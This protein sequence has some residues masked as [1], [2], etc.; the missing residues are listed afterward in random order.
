MQLQGLAQP[1]ELHNVQQ[2]SS[3]F[4]IAMNAK[5]FRVLSS[6]IYQDKIGSIVREL[7]ANAMDAHVM[8]GVDRPFRIHFPDQFEP[9]FEVQDYGTGIAPDKI[10]SVFTVYFN[11][12]KDQSNDVI[13]AFGLGS[14]TPF[15]YTDQFTV[16]N[17]YNGKQYIYSAF[18]AA[19]GQPS[20]VLLDE[21]DTIECNGL[22]ISM[23]VKA[24]D[25]RKFAEAA[26]VQLRFLENQPV[27][28]NAPYG[29]EVVN[30]FKDAEI[31]AQAQGFVLARNDQ[32][33]NFAYAVQGQI[34]YAIDT[35]K[36]DITHPS[37]KFLKHLLEFSSIRIDFN[38]G[39][40]GV[41]ASREAVEYTP[42]TVK[43]IRDKIAAIQSDLILSYQQ[44]I[45]QQATNWD[46]AV[47]A[48]S[49]DMFSIGA[50]FNAYFKPQFASPSS[51]HNEWRFALPTGVVA[52][53]KSYYGRRSEGNRYVTPT[54]T[55]KVYV[56]TAD[57][58]Y[59]QKRTTE[60]F[61][62]LSYNDIVV[63]IKFDKDQTNIEEIKKALG[64]CSDLKMLSD[65]PVVVEPRARAA[66]VKSTAWVIK[67]YDIRNVKKWER[68]TE[69]FE[70][71]F[72][73]DCIVFPVAAY[74]EVSGSV[75]TQLLTL[76]KYNTAMY[77]LS[78]NIY[79]VREKDYQQ[80][81]DLGAKPLGEYVANIT[82]EATQMAKAVKSAS[83]YKKMAANSDWIEH[84]NSV[85]G[86]DI[87]DYPQEVQKAQRVL[88]KLKTNWRT[89][90]KSRVRNDY[91]L[92]TYFGSENNQ[93]VC[94]PVV[95]GAVEKIKEY[96]NTTPIF[97]V[98][99]YQLRNIA[100]EQLRML[101]KVRTVTDQKGVNDGNEQW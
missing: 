72:D 21:S 1:V 54:K 77:N 92:Q 26:K 46:I 53:I 57:C 73:S 75:N 88:E 89:K 5:A 67:K 42:E 68:V 47:E 38:I 32:T 16:T 6:T 78:D 8:A 56:Q 7:S 83:N 2:S 86:L 64:G 69:D 62:S 81:I 63:L 66:G 101:M 60:I 100:T 39:E 9:H 44:R 80:A 59:K 84:N 43:V 97:K 30:P 35:D 94:H 27:Y 17:R 50:G 20:L 29:F 74:R 24:E 87:E 14:K 79:A 3:G 82:E 96:M 95:E 49:M 76:D 40:I 93:G 36:L 11:S 34:G 31:L 13:G 15:S 55:T 70:K 41:T 52:I 25:Y 71:L 45:Q 98:D 91:Y 22:C 12:T 90:L 65:V 48:N 4:Q 58:T 99:R 33:V 28:E 85:L 61:T 18:V 23:S 37:I 19:D 10:H 51:F